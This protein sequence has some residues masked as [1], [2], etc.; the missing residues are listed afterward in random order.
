MYKAIN[1]IRERKGFTLIELLIVVAIIGIL[2][3]IAI[4]AYIGAQEKARKSNL[5]RAA[6]SCEADVQHWINSAIKGVNTSTAGN[7]LREVDT[8][9]S[10]AIEA[11]DQKNTQLFNIGA[12][13]AKGVALQYTT[14]RTG[15]DAAIN[16]KETS[17]WS[18]MSKCITSNGWL[19]TSTDAIAANTKGA[20]CKVT[21]SAQAAPAGAVTGNSVRVIGTSNGPGGNDSDNSE[22]MTSTLVTAE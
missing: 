14:A 1:N 9:W 12:D 2:A 15:S 10:G 16:G 7:N 20:Y 17:P 4:P 11:S 13:A 18:G 22:L 19:F 21:L 3:A 8:N 5:N 6:K